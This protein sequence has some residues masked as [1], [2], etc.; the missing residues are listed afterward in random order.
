MGAC[1][2]R[3]AERSIRCSTL[4]SDH[5]PP[6]IAKGKG[7]GGRGELVFLAEEENVVGGMG[8]LHPVPEQDMQKRVQ[9]SSTPRR[10]GSAQNRIE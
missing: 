6:P 8:G 5:R 2:Q 3:A 9:S 1:Q 7:L 10:S 4:K